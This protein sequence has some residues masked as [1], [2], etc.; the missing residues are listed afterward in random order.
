VQVYN[1]G[2][3]AL[4]KNANVKGFITAICIRGIQITYE[5]CY[6]LNGVY[7]SHWFNDYEFVVTD[8]A[9]KEKIGF[10]DKGVK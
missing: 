9:A 6:Y 1:C 5:I 4:I 2:N 7:N 8:L 3:E 10:I